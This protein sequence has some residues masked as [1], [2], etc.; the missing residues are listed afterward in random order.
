MMK[1]QFHV[2]CIDRATQFHNTIELVIRPDLTFEA[3][4]VIGPV[5]HHIGT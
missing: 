3:M 5:T 4:R 1:F 2:K